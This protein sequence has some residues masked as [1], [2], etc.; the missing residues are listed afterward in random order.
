MKQKWVKAERIFLLFWNLV[1][2]D[3]VVDYRYFDRRRADRWAQ[4]LGEI[5]AETLCDGAQG[6]TG[7]G[8]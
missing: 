1:K 7:N 5:Y 3:Y 6:F 4:C 2:T 8:W